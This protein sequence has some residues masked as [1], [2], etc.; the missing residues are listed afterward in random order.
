MNDLY[1]IK[2][3]LVPIGASALAPRNYLKES[4]WSK[5]KLKR[6][7][8]IEGM[9]CEYCKCNHLAIHLHESF[10]IKSNTY[11]LTGVH[12]LCTQCHSDVHKVNPYTTWV[13]FIEESK[14]PFYTHKIVDYSYLKYY[15]IDH[16]GIEHKFY[17]GKKYNSEVNL[18]RATDLILRTHRDEFGDYIIGMKKHIN[19]DLLFAF[20]GIKASLRLFNYIEEHYCKYKEFKI[21]GSLLTNQISGFN[22]KVLINFGFKKEKELV[23][24]I[25]YTFELEQYP[26]SNRKLTKKDITIMNNAYKKSEDAKS[27]LTGMDSLITIKSKWNDKQK[28][29]EQYEIYKELNR[30]YMFM[31]AEYSAM[32]RKTIIR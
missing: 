29:V 16:E 8:D 9:Y 32:H 23:D 13:N 14:F 26:F 5:I 27:L 4:E 10:I 31:C 2:K 11:K 18:I 6:A 15:G 28:V 22:E 1:Q 25:K 17:N 19:K 7:S 21:F 12:L 3:E 30:Q 24:N 20:D